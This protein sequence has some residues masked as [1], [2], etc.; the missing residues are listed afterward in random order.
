MRKLDK[1]RYSLR[2]VEKFEGVNLSYYMLRFNPSGWAQIFLHQAGSNGTFSC[3]SDWGNYSYNWSGV[4]EGIDFRQWLAGLIEKEERNDYAGYLIEKLSVGSVLDSRQAQVL[5]KDQTYQNVVEKLKEWV[6]SDKMRS[7]E[8]EEVQEHLDE[9]WDDVEDAKDIWYK[10]EDKLAEMFME[11][12]Y[13][14]CHREPPVLVGF[15]KEILPHFARVLRGTHEIKSTVHLSL[16]SATSVFS[17]G[18]KD[19]SE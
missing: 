10:A 17:E 8:A 7:T 11:D 5:D 6:Q 15:V 9:I 16:V 14:I 18:L 12:S 19:Q 13:L 1:D 2:S 4:P 3:L